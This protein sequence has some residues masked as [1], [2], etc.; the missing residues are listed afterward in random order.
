NSLPPC[1]HFLPDFA[2]HPP[3]PVRV[4][5]DDLRPKF[6]PP[7]VEENR[8]KDLDDLAFLPLSAQANL[9]RNKKIS[10]TELAKLALARFKQY[11]PALKCVISLT[12]EV[13]LKQ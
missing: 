13:A 3:K 5:P 12:E 11:D 4:N 8:P 9:I 1:I 7:E 2:P 6:G 10:S